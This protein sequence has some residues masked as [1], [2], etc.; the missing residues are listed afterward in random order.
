MASFADSLSEFAY[1]ITQYL[2][3]E[4]GYNADFL[5]FTKKWPRGG[6]LQVHGRGAENMAPETYSPAKIPRRENCG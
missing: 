3:R 2:G 5:K 1:K 6:F 4:Q